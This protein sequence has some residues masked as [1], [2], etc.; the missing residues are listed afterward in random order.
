MTLA[1]HVLLRISNQMKTLSQKGQWLIF[2]KI[3]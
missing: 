2:S 1:Q 3:H